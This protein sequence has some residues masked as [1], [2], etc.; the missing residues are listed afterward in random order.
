M[1]INNKN[2]QNTCEI[3]GTVLNSSQ[4]LTDLIF[5]TTMQDRFYYCAH[6]SGKETEAQNGKVMS[7]DYTKSERQRWNLN[8][9]SLA[10][11]PCTL[12]I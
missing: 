1:K 12:P 3:S 4:V 11:R 5:S 10:A 2:Q 6:I 8:P 7:Q 9:G